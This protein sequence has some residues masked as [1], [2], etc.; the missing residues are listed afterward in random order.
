MFSEFIDSLAQALC[1]HSLKCAYSV[2]AI[3]VIYNVLLHYVLICLLLGIATGFFTVTIIK[4]N[5]KITE[6]NHTNQKL[7][8][9]TEQ[10]RLFHVDHHD[11]PSPD[12]EYSSDGRLK[13]SHFSSRKGR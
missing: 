12:L 2:I 4:Y 1:R 8:T 5:S 11:L 3:L 10:L 7:D 13:W 6:I 9:Y